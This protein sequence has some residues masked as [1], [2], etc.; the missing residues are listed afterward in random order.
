MQL[1]SYGTNTEFWRTVFE[2]SIPRDESPRA[3]Q[4]ESWLI[5]LAYSAQFGLPPN[6]TPLN[7][8]A[9]VSYSSCMPEKLS[10]T[11]TV[12]VI[13]WVSCSR[14]SVKGLVQPDDKAAVKPTDC[15]QIVS[16]S[17]L[18]PC[19]IAL[20][21]HSM[22]LH[23]QVD[24]R[25]LCETQHYPVNVHPTTATAIGAAFCRFHQQQI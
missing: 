17:S 8:S 14:H 21:F 24:S 19:I 10:H 23:L 22:L 1:G 3:R 12:M 5:V 13:E 16:V 11:S 18:K 20:P 2:G 25:Q 7:S 6:V 4:Q 9:F 15:N